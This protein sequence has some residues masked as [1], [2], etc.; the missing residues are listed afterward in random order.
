VVIRHVDKIHRVG[1][2]GGLVLGERFAAVA[3]IVVVV[4]VALVVQA[5]A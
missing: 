4:V 5:P 1:S 3:A 2:V